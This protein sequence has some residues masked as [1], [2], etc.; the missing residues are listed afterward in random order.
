MVPASTWKWHNGKSGE[1][2]N[3][4]KDEKKESKWEGGGRREERSGRE[5]EEGEGEREVEYRLNDVTM[6]SPS[7]E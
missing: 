7:L 4:R 6:Q 5:K 3:K 1:K 2:E